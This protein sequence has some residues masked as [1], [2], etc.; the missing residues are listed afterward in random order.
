MFDV[1]ESRLSLALI[2]LQLCAPPRRLLFV[3][4]LL[5]QI[6]QLLQ[7]KVSELRGLIRVPVKFSSE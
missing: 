2:L 1:S 4:V 5:L 7:V 6:L 3:F